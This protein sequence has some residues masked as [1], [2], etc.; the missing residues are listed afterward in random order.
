MFVNITISFFTPYI[1]FVSIFNSNLSSDW[2]FPV[3][4]GVLVTILGVI[5][6]KLVAKIQK[7]KQ[8]DP[9]ELSTAA[10]SNAVNFPIPIIYELYPASL[11][12]AGIFIVV[13]IVMRNTVGF[14]IAGYKLN[15]EGI[16]A[17]FLFPPVWG[18]ILGFVLKLVVDQQTVN[19][20]LISQPA[21]ILF[22]IGIYMT[23]MTVGFGMT[24]LKIT[25]P[26][27]VLRV[28]I[29]RYLVSGIVAVLIIFSLK[30]KPILSVPLFVQFVAPPAV[31]NGLYAEKLDMNTTMT[32]NIIIILTFIALLLLPLEL[33][34]VITLL[35]PS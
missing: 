16:K 5:I 32:S 2:I 13:A 20:I 10:F 25:Y 34:F 27:E 29:T 23:L 30:L 26:K 35:L 17:T 21:T 3:G 15:W 24:S 18:V 28:G 22:Q 19:P 33:F 11:G 8:P 1:I 9:A 4:A 12:V 6:P 7:E 14:W 31:Y